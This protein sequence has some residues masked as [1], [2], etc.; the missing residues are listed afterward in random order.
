VNLICTI[1][2]MKGAIKSILHVSHQIVIMSIELLTF[3]VK[4]DLC[5]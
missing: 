1:D 3:V 5:E 4:D 2:D